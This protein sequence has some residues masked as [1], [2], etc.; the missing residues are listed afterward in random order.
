ME[1]IN[2]IKQVVKIMEFGGESTKKISRVVL[3]NRNTKVE[4]KEKA[5]CV[6]IDV[7]FK[8]NGLQ[9]GFRGL[10]DTKGIG[11]QM[12][13]EQYKLQKNI[14]IVLICEETGEEFQIN[15]FFNIELRTQADYK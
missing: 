6:S 3:L 2:R 12:F 11:F 13:L 7:K 10:A 1:E 14:M 4:I 9:T 15:G 5:D 8:E